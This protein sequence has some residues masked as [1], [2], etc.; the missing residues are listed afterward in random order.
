MREQDT[1][2]VRQ[3]IVALNTVEAELRAIRCATD[4][5]ERLALV[6]RKQAILHELRRRRRRHPIRSSVA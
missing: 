5:A 2:S 1:T 4:S 6:R 3:L